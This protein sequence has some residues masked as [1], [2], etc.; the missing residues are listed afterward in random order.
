MRSDN[1]RSA[2][3]IGRQRGGAYVEAWSWSAPVDAFVREVIEERPL[4]NVC[5][6]A[7][8][9]GDVTMDKHHPR[10]DVQGDWLSLPFGDD[11]FAAVFSDPP[12]N[13]GYKADTAH[14]VQEA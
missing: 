4:L 13:A 8:D 7:S 12:W 14:F 2:P 1:S 5:S 6:G 10:A 3:R 11:S 9:F